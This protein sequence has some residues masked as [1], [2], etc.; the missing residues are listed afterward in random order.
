VIN[1]FVE[2][3]TSTLLL[4][5]PEDLIKPVKTINFTLP[6]VGITSMLWSKDGDT[7]YITADNNIYQ[8]NTN[9]GEV[10][11]ILYDPSVSIRG[12]VF[13]FSQRY[14]VYVSPPEGNGIKQVIKA[15]DLQYNY[16][17]IPLLTEDFIYFQYQSW[18]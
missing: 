3:Y 9:T 13:S 17:V 12:T 5:N 14:I 2:G 16:K 10:K 18:N 1:T 8:L 6:I 4:Y 11:S 7:V 15:V